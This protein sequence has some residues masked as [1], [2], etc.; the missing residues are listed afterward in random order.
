MEKRGILKKYIENLQIF[1]AF[2]TNNSP[3]RGQLRGLIKGLIRGKK[4]VIRGK[5]GVIRGKMGNLK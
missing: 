2:L 5:R 1:N 3:I 4:G